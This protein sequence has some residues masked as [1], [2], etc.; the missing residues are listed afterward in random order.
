MLLC[1]FVELAYKNALEMGLDPDEQD[2]YVRESLAQAI[3]QGRV[4]SEG[5][6]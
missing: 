6:I 3:E 4:C 5:D 1:E 2:W